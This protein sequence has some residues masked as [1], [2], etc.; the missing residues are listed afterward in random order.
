MTFLLRQCIVTQE[1]KAFHNRKGTANALDIK[2][3]F[4]QTIKRE[5]WIKYNIY[6]NLGRTTYFRNLFAIND[7][8]ITWEDNQWQILT[9]FDINDN[10]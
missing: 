6:Q 7:Y 5:V 9:L 1:R 4:N 8:L 2:L 10:T 3:A